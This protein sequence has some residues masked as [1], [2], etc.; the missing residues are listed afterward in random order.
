MAEP[1]KGI[2][3]AQHK[4]TRWHE[5]SAHGANPLPGGHPAVASHHRF[6]IE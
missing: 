6:P 2:K 5:G 4:F 1:D 3:D